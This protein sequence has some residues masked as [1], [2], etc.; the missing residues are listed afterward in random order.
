M[1][2]PFLFPEPLGSHYRYFLRFLFF[3]VKEKIFFIF[4]RGHYL[5]FL[6]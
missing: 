2:W 4:S 3:L 1:F 5:P 6:Y